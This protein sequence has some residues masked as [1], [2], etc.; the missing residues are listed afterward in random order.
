MLRIINEPTAAA[1]AYGLEKND[2]KKIAVYDLG[3]GTFDISILEIGDGVFEVKATNGDTFLG[4]EDFD[5]RIVDYLADEFKKE[6]SVDLRKDKLALQR[7]KEEAEK[8]KKELSSTAQ[9]EVNLPFIS[10]NASGPLHLNIKLSRAKL[11]ALVEDLIAKTIGPCEQALKDA[12]LKK[13]DID[14]VVLV[15]GMT[16][17]PKVVE[18]VK[19][20]FGRE[21]HK[22]VNPDEV[23]ALG[24]AIQAGVLQGDVKDVLLLDVTPLTLGIETLGGVFTPLIER[25]TTIPTK[26]SQTFSTADDNQSAVTIRV[27]QGERPM[28]AGQQAAGPVRPGRHPAGAARRAA[29][30]GHLRHRRQR[31]RQR[32]RPR[33]RRPTRSSRSASRPT[34]ASRTPTSTEMVKEAEAHKADDEKRKALVE[35]SNQADAAVHSTEKA[36]AEH[37]D[38]IGADDKSAIETALADLKSALEGEDAEAIS[39][40]TQTL[41]QASMKLGEAMYKA[42]AGEAAAAARSAQAP[43]TAWSTPS[44]KKSTTSQN[45]GVIA[46]T[47]DHGR[48]AAHR[49]RRPPVAKSGRLRPTSC[50]GRRRSSAMA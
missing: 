40:K 45:S 31:H 41:L 43:T 18:A 6:T 37:G 24:A 39:A 8:A 14:E 47:F 33:T 16:R 19:E 30:R 28:A 35:A 25:N 36:L 26:R 15:G 42:Q 12:G 38:K 11:E 1:L 22:G 21:P 46:R 34:A 27:F 50:T 3:G 13:T 20:F 2:G 49:R 48:F 44:S 9:Y 29:G 4:G 10:M 23:V 7:L 32:R 17:M 5:L